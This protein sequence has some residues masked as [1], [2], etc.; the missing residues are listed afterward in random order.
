MRTVSEQEMKSLRNHVSESQRVSQVSNLIAV[1][2]KRIPANM[3]KQTHLFMN[4][5]FAYT[6]AGMHIFLRTAKYFRTG[7]SWERLKKKKGSG[8]RVLPSLVSF[9]HPVVR[10]G[11][12]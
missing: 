4:L 5:T 8:Q 6:L 3:Q 10:R 12:P 9:L 11:E 2:D 7:S 1:G